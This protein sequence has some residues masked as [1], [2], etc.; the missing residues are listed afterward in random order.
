MQL[1]LEALG[2]GEGGYLLVKRALRQTRPGERLIVKGRAPGL[3]VDLRAWC[4]AGGHRFEWY[5]APDATEGHAA[6]I[7]GPA[8]GDR[9][10]DA[11]RAAGNSGP[12]VDAVAEH[13]PRTWGLAARGAVIEAGAPSFDFHLVD[14]IEVWSDDACA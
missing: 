8:E 1:D 10:A 4:R 2:F 6:V 3:D 13:P 12:P 11:E 9:W 14:K 5:A 7:M